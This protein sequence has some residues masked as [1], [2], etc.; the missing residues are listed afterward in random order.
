MAKTLK[1]I[2]NVIEENKFYIVEKLED[3]SFAIYRKQKG[4][5]IYCEEYAL[6]ASTVVYK[7]NGVSYLHNEDVP[8]KHGQ[9]N[10][11]AVR[12]EIDSWRLKGQDLIVKYFDEKNY[13]FIRHVDEN[14]NLY[15]KTRKIESVEPSTIPMI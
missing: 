5:V 10:T 12:F 8:Q 14:G 3:G 15:K 11:P 1:S 6:R 7:S 2:K 4:T 9:G 13:K